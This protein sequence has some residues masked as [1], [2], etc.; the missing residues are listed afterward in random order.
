MLEMYCDMMRDSS[1]LMIVI[2]LFFYCLGYFLIEYGFYQGIV[3][4][5]PMAIVLSF[6][7]KWQHSVPGGP[8]RFTIKYFQPCNIF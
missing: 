6:S 5:T 8:F 1:W 7:I 2:Y 4:G 3:V